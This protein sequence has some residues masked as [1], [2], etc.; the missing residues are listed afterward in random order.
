[1]ITKAGKQAIQTMTNQTSTNLA[2]SVKAMFPE[3]S[4]KN[5]DGNERQISHLNG[6]LVSSSNIVVNRNAGFSI[7]SGTTTPTEND[8]FLESQIT[9]GYTMIL[10][11]ATRNVDENNNLYM[12]FTFTI[13]NNS[14]NTLTIAE[15]GLT[16]A[17]IYCLNSSSATT[18]STNN[19]MIDRTTFE[20]PITIASTET[21]ALR[22]RITSDMSFT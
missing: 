6:N 5:V 4:I 1:M 18:G 16:T 3:D 13:T 11:G 15:I 21:A 7:G 9:S 10:T 8:F 22:Y 12:E 2:G 17:N 19:I 20:T 14:S